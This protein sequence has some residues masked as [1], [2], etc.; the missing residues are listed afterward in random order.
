MFLAL[1]CSA[2]AGVPVVD[3]GFTGLMMLDE[4]IGFG[5]CDGGEKRGDETEACWYGSGCG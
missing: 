2:G 4:W 5:V 1:F 3:D